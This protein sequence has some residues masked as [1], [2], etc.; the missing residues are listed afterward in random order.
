MAQQGTPAGSERRT[1]ARLPY[2]MPCE[3]SYQGAKLGG[4]VTDV[5]ARGLFVESSHRIPEGVE[6]RLLLRDPH[7]PFEVM[8]H[9]VRQKRS[10]RS[11]RQVVSAGF[12]VELDVI[13]EPFFRLLVELGLG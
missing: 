2:R 8:G 4:I 5:A 6:L 10:H 13:P 7:G 3:F 1:F 11:A 12:S 9:V